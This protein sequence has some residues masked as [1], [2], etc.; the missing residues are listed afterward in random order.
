MSEHGRDQQVA[1]AAAD[2]GQVLRSVDVIIWEGDPVT[3]RFSFVSEQAER[4][5]GYPIQAWLAQDFW[6]EHVHPSDRDWVVEL[7][8]KASEA[9][10]PHALEYRMI[11]ADGSVVWLRDVVS[12]DMEDGRAIRSHGVMVDVTERRRAEEARLTAEMR[13]RTVVANAPVV[14]FAVD[15]GGTITLCEGRGLESVGID[16]ATAV[17]RSYRDQHA[18]IRESI[19]LALAGQSFCRNVTIRGR[20]F[21]TSYS[22]LH[23]EAGERQGV[24]GVGTDVT[25][26]LKAQGDRDRLEAEVRHAQK[27]ESLGVLAGGIAHDFNN[28]L[29]SIL[30]NADLTLVNMPRSAQGRAHLE[31]I[32]D[33]GRRL[34]A[35][36]HQLLAYSGKATF[37]VEALDLSRLVEEM[38]HL[39]AVGVSKKGVLRYELAHD[40]PAVD[41]DSSQIGQV[42]MNLVTNASDALGESSGSIALRTGVM[43]VHREDL[44]Q[45]YI[46]DDCA[47]G[48]Y[49]FLEV[50]DSGAGMD[51]ETQGR[52]FDPFYTTKSSG[53]GLGLA[54]VLGIVR[55]HRGAVSVCS[56]PGEGTTFRVLIPCSQAEP[57]RKREQPGSTLAW[58]GAERVLVVDDEPDVRE[59]TETML[60]HLGLQVLTA[61]D[62]QA[63]LDLLRAHAN[64]VD[65]VL[66]DLTM[67]GLGGTEVLEQIERIRRDLPVVL[68]SGYNEGYSARGCA[69]RIAG[70]LQK[71]FSSEQLGQLLRSVLPRSD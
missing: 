27:L 10:E 38:E 16:P 62:G 60:R 65:L 13:L 17:G 22:A 21:E 47:E 32:R 69:D 4:I 43:D 29:T 12:V 24:I 18:Q 67:P 48:L 68:M 14:L 2:Y 26:R 19:G 5:T 51:A 64:E 36:T 30:G 42:V 6:V 9:G 1:P 50:Q 56:E 63:A 23:D 53:R 52:I 39:L 7:C 15:A 49:A 61:V 45:A 20:T 35:L 59:L 44:S 55:S 34:S 31:R 41:G 46:F 70:F 66:L 37:V 8:K 58:R 54:V 33:A 57:A 3:L 25:E 28:M 11:A 71:P 40:L